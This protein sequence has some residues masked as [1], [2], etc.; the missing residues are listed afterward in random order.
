M[1]NIP[2]GKQFIDREDKKLVISSLSNDLITTGPY[3]KKFEKELS[4]YFKSKYSYVCSSGTAAIHLAMMSLKLKK[5]DT[6]LMPAI[7]FIA[8]YNIAKIMNLKVY[9]IDVDEF[10]GQITPEKVLECIKINKLKKIKA[11]LIMFHGGFPEYSKKLYDI[12]K[13]YNFYIIEDACHALGSEYE[14]KKK[15]YKVGSCKHSDISTF[16]MHPLKT[17][18]TGEGGIITTNNSKIA[19]NIKLLR[20]HGMI[21]DKKKYWKYDIIEHGLNYRLSDI[22]CALGISQLK[23][24]NF[25][26]KKREKIFTKYY[27]EFNNFN[28][29]LKLPQYSKNIKPSYHLFLIHILFNKLKTSKDHFLKYLN[30]HN[31][32]GQYH[33]IP[34]NKFSVYNEKK[35][36]LIGTEKYFKNSISIPIFVNLNY[37]DQN[38]VIKVIKNYFKT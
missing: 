2:Y 8:S 1:R 7:N 15:L 23:K 4:K 25:F 13:E 26:L 16:S 31:I 29:N 18:T 3:V 21:K 10:T 17:I 36:S 24:I 6:I 12:K 38:K 30:N 9:L 37:R 35:K 33:Y 27:K 19:K 34:I 14:Y 32:I 20:S 28:N 22:N 11:L 5:N